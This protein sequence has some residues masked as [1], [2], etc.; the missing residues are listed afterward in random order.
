MEN[1][2]WRIDYDHLNRHPHEYVT[3][4]KTGSSFQAHIGILCVL[5]FGLISSLA[6]FFYSLFDC[7][8]Y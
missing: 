4:C 1:E 2:S 3:F 6:F 5:G 7:Q 8:P